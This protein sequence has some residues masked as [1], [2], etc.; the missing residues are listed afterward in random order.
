MIPLNDCESS[1][2]LSHTLLW[3]LG[4]VIWGMGKL[5]LLLIGMF[6]DQYIF[7]LTHVRNLRLSRADAHLTSY[8][9]QASLILFLAKE[10]VEAFV[11]SLGRFLNPI[12]KIFALGP[13]ESATNKPIYI[14]YQEKVFFLKKK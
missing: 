13:K 1:S 4:K 5:H 7:G 11:H 3:E 10:F 8:S 6:P 9:E 12:I 2:H 14:L